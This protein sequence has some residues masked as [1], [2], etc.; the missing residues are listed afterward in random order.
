VTESSLTP[1]P[2]EPLTGGP[3]AQ[4]QDDRPSDDQFLRSLVRDPEPPV[5]EVSDD[6]IQPTLTDKATDDDDT[7]DDSGDDSQR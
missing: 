5:D 2:D 1:P 6:E 3:G 7:S 4:A